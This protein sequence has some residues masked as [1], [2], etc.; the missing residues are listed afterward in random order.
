MKND[1]VNIQSIKI[2]LEEIE[3][4]F[5]ESDGIDKIE[6]VKKKKDNFIKTNNVLDVKELTDY[7]KGWII[8]YYSGIIEFRPIENEEGSTQLN[9]KIDKAFTDQI[10]SMCLKSVIKVCESQTEVLKQTFDKHCKGIKA[11]SGKNLI[12]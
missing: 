2:N 10:V 12:E 11:E 1:Q 4:S 3:F 9:I 6:A 5:Y 7:R 8:S